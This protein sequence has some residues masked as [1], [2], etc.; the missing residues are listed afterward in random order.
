MKY[1]YKFTIYQ[2]S[3]TPNLWKYGA[4]LEKIVKYMY[5]EGLPDLNYL[6]NSNPK[7]KIKYL[8]KVEK[9]EPF[10]INREIK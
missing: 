10:I 4:N 3:A 2:Y 5:F 7:F 8:G 9:G 6:I 1:L